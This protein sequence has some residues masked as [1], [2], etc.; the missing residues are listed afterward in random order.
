M[1]KVAVIYCICFIISCSGNESEDA[2]N[3]YKSGC[4][5]LLPGQTNT[6]SLNQVCLVDL[7]GN[8]STGYWWYYTNSSPAGFAF[9]EYN[10]FAIYG[11][12]T[13][14]PVQ[15]VW[16]FKGTGAGATTLIYKYY[17]SWVGEASAIKTNEYFIEFN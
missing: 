12:Q 2:Y 11:D 5:S 9:Q 17:Q 3:Q 13:G 7:Q 15:I 4:Y 6:I 10:T 8:G 16:K 1:K 14:A